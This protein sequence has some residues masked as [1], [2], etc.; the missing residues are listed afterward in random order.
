[1]LKEARQGTA[2]ANRGVAK[3]AMQECAVK[4]FEAQGRP[5]RT[6]FALHKV[7]IREV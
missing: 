1:M 3:V 4:R 6:L 5:Q 2:A 7:F